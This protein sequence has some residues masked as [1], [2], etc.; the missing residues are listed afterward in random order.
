MWWKNGKKAGAENRI[1]VEGLVIMA[2]PQKRTGG[3][4]RI[5]YGRLNGRRE[6]RV[7]QS[8]QARKHCL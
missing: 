4:K 6:S 7:R 8:A 1:E 2:P 5:D 3:G